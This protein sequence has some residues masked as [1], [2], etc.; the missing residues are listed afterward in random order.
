M[1]A[2]GS[3]SVNAGSGDA[4]ASDACHAMRCLRTGLVAAALPFRDCPALQS[5]CLPPVAP[6]TLPDMRQTSCRPACA[7]AQKPIPLRA[8]ICTCARVPEGRP[9]GPGLAA[10]QHETDARKTR[11]VATSHASI[12]NHSAAGISRSRSWPVGCGCVRQPGPLTR[13]HVAGY[14]CRKT[15]QTVVGSS[16][17]NSCAPHGLRRMTLAFG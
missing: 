10:T 12:H 17:A 16:T 14:H 5:H 2:C 13:R 7:S 11:R 3:S 9:N 15:T 6:A 4:V 1:E 8:A